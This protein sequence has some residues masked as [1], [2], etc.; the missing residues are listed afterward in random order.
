MSEAPTTTSREGAPQEQ[1]VS[2]RRDL[3]ED[4]HD[5][6]R[7]SFRRFLEREVTPSY[8]EWRKSGIPRELFRE[9]AAHQFVGASVPEAYGGAGIEDF[10]FGAVIAEEAMRANAAGLALMLVSLNEVCVPL[11][12]ELAGPDGGAWLEGIAAG[13]LV[14]ALAAPEQ[15]I[16]AERSDDGLVLEGSALGVINGGLAE[17]VIVAVSTGESDDL[18][19][20]VLDANAEGVNRTASGE[21]VGPHPCDRAD[22]SF[23]G[24]AVPDSALLVGDV[25]RALADAALSERLGVAVMGVAGARAALAETLAYVHDRRAFGRPI[26]EFENTRFALA[27]MSAEID[28]TES[29][30][31]GCV[32]DYA[33]GRLDGP[34]FAAAKLQATELFGRVADWGVQLHGGYGYM[35]EY[36]ISH[37]FTAARYLRLH[38]GTSEEMK[39]IVADSIGL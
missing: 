1:P 5:A 15:P 30:V 32:A 12:S 19:L 26:A 4:E 39:G 9:L 24:T 31:D 16:R 14:A 2:R 34:R 11:L 3:F 37:A 33:E 23:E 13:D 35:L 7:E 27:A 36:P 22:L 21:L 6:F 20:A 28:A 29:F 38:A 25:A 17:L 18:A 8:A 10:R